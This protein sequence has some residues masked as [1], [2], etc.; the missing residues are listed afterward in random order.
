M[1]MHRADVERY[2]S[3]L[4]PDEQF[5]LD[6]D[7]GT[8]LMSYEDWKDHFST[9]FLNNDFPED[10]TGVRFKSSWT[11]QNSGGLPQHYEAVHLQRY[12]RNPQFLIQPK[13]DCQLMFSM[14]QTGGRLPKTRGVYSQYPFSDSLHYACVGVFE[15]QANEPDCLQ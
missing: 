8:F 11:V 9:L 3:N 2:I 7:D 4:P 5:E 6:A 13:N 15:L 14:Q 10:W 12:A 1:L